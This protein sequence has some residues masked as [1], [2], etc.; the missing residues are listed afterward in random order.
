LHGLSPGD[1]VRGQVER[2]G[3][4]YKLTLR[5][6]VAD[7]RPF[8]KALTGPGRK[9][10]DGPGKE[11]EADLSF[12]IL[13]G[14]NDEA[15]TNASLRLSLRGDDLRQG[16]IQGR[17]K[18]AAVTVEVARGE[19]GAP[20][21]LSAESGDAGA[22][23]RFLDI[24]RRMY[25]GRLQ[26]QTTMNDGPQSGAVQIRSFVLRDEPALGRIMAQGDPGGDDHL[27]QSGRREVNDVGFD[28]LSADFVR[29][30]TRIEVSEAAISGPAMGFTLRGWL[31][32]GRNRTDI[33][34][35][36]VPLYGL[37][38]VVSH[39]PIFGPLLGGGSN[40]GLFGINFQV[41]GMMSAPNVSVNPLSAI[42]PGFLRKLFGAGGPPQAAR[43]ER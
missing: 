14:F 22:V 34:G 13:T 7:A 10:K 27:N 3:G 43:P 11:V 8:L 26:L 39:V 15:L 5:G 20:P 36:F 28:R 40:E 17:L 1:D 41:S 2:S 35:T 29:T 31:D 33:A 42:A 12:A 19:R 38:N 25:G 30:G 6:G 21:V 37:N 23:L 32:T 9:G 4:A 16:R 24:Y 18:G